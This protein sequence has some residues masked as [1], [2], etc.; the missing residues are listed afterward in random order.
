VLII[1]GIKLLGHHDIPQIE[2]VSFSLSN[3]KDS[4]D[5]LRSNL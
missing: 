3:F 4:S 2:S 1:V 5:K